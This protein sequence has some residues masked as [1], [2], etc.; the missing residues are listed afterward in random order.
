VGAGRIEK[1]G[2]RQRKRSCRAVHT[3]LGY[4]KKITR[5]RKARRDR[6][7]ERKSLF[8]LLFFTPGRR[9]RAMVVEYRVE[10][11]INVSIL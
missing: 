11:K 5:K 1:E 9:T 8:F 6:E 10:W 3:L 2:E 4:G 7:R